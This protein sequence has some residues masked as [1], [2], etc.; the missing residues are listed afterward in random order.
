MNR[1]RIPRDIEI[2]KYLVLLIGI[3][4][5]IVLFGTFGDSEATAVC[6]IFLIV[7]IVLFYLLHHSKTVEFD[8]HFMY[9]TGRQISKK[10]PLERVYQ[11]KF[12]MTQIN[13][14]HMWKIG[15]YDESN[16]EQSVRILPKV[17]DKS[18]D[19]FTDKVKEKNHQVKVKSW[20][21]SF[22]FD[23]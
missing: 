8:D 16:E 11:I 10:V 21:H 7:C 3:V 22:D 5:I 19:K 9:I 13:R 20:S 15:Y 18:F 6:F 12:T 2:G 17:S 4:V 23:Q 1:I 14:Q